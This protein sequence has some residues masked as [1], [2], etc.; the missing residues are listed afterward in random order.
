L[1]PLLRRGDVLLFAFQAHMLDKTRVGVF[2]DDVIELCAIVIDETDPLDDNV[3]GFPVI[4]L[5]QQTVFHGSRLAASTHNLRVYG[6]IVTTDILFG[7]AHALSPAAIALNAVDIGALEQ[8]REQ[9][10]E[11]FLLLWGERAPVLAERALCHLFEPKALEHCLP[12]LGAALLR[13]ELFIIQDSQHVVDGLTDL[14]LGF[15]GLRAHGRTDQQHATNQH[16]H[17]ETSRPLAHKRSP[18]YAVVYPHTFCSYLHRCK[19]RTI[20][21]GAEGN[22]PALILRKCLRRASGAGRGA[23]PA[24]WH[25]G[26]SGPLPRP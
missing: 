20:K 14:V 1:L 17:D 24:L 19:G 15:T 25:S 2:H 16:P 12:N 21:T 9:L 11:L 8:I 5:V 23:D 3:I 26:R 4:I 18:W 22:L 7:I 6:G 10:H 13:L